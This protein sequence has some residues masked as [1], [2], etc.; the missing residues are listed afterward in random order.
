MFI[1][2]K[3][4]LFH[5][6]LFVCICAIV[7]SG[8]VLGTVFGQH[9]EMMPRLMPIN[10]V[11][12][13]YREQME[14]VY[15]SISATSGHT[16][17][18]MP[19]P[20][21]LSHLADLSITR[22]LPFSVYYQPP[23]GRYDLREEDR[24]TPVKDQGWCGSC[25]AFATMS[26]LESNLLPDEAWNFSENHLKN[27]SG[28]DLGHCDGGNYEMSMAYMAN[29]SGPVEEDDDPYDIDSGVSQ[30]NLT[31]LK[32][33]QKVEI[34]PRRTDFLDNDIIK[35]A[36][37][38]NGALGTTMRWEDA[39]YDPSTFSYYYS[40]A[41]YH[42]HAVAIVGWD[43]N[44]SV[45]HFL[46]NPPGNGAFIVRNSWGDSWGDGG[47][48][49]I[50]YYDTTIAGHPNFLFNSAEETYNYSGV[51]QYDPLGWSGLSGYNNDTAWAANIFRAVA[52]EAI[53]AVG[54]YATSADA[55]YTLY[56]YVDVGSDP[57]SG[58]LAAGPITGGL[59]FAGY[60]TVPLP[61]PVLV[62][63]GQTFSVVLRATTPGFSFPIAIERPIN[64]YSSAAIAQKGQSFQSQYGRLWT[65][66]TTLFANTNVCIK[67]FVQP[68]EEVDH[69][70]SAIDALEPSSAHKGGSAF[71]LTVDGANFV[72]ASRV[73]FNGMDCNT[74]FV[75]N[76]LLTAQIP[77]T[78]LMDAG[79]VDV[80]VFNPEPGGGLSNVLVFAIVDAPEGAGNV[81]GASGG[82][83]GGC[84]IHTVMQIMH[85]MNN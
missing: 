46:G 25:W 29:W 75:S 76:T 18:Y 80:S 9:T 34:I 8:V 26:S 59:T 41:D 4:K 43:D 13:E 53:T 33:V 35:K 3:N 52:E 66:I 57:R 85:Q 23:P 15:Q 6:F 81:V 50:S 63:E 39:S 56:V 84:F 31:A 60:H 79:T 32:H 55:D 5:R 74:T 10:P 19:S 48:F 72:A 27:T 20:V 42:N 28:F 70:V 2:L 78:A 51:Y 83:G 36:V 17:G 44:Y 37:M 1:D 49:Y 21:D 64:G 54:F 77:D 7:G 14:S 22:V 73:R 40:G 82:G 47:Y 38:D 30:P 69:P 16:L 71:I 61:A 58:I 24:L 11:F 45:D 65:D 68:I 12:V 62:S 67:A